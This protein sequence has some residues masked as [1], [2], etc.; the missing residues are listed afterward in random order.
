M[1]WTYLRFDG[2]GDYLPGEKD[3]LPEDGTAFLAFDALR[4][5]VVIGYR[6]R[7]GYVSMLNPNVCDDCDVV[8]IAPLSEGSDPDEESIRAASPDREWD[9]YPCYKLESNRV[10]LSR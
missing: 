2:K 7:G 6:E 3:K 4:W 8:A 5:S 10:A 9:H 1:A